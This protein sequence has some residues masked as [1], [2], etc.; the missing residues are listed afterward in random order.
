MLKRPEITASGMFR[1]GRNGRK[2]KSYKNL[3]QTPIPIKVLHS[4]V[5]STKGCRL[6]VTITLTKR[7]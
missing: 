3:K 5:E 6:V 2:T 7:K 1:L 4:D